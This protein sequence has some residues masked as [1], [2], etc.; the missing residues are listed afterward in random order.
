[1]CFFAITLNNLV[2]KARL[3]AGP[4]DGSTC[5]PFQRDDPDRGLVPG[6]GFD[7]TT[8]SH[9]NEAFGF[10]NI[11]VNWDYSPSRELTAMVYPTFEYLLII[12]LCFDFLATCLAQK[13]GDLAPWFWKFSQ[14][15]FGL[16]L[17]FC[18]QFRMIFVC[19]AYS[20]VRAHTAGFLGLQV[21]LI[22]VAMHNV[23]F[24][25][26]S[27]IAY[28]QLGGDDGGLANTRRAAVTYL[29]LDATI[30]I[31]KVSAT[32]Y[33]VATGHGAAWT[34][35]DTSIPNFKVGRIVDV[36]W[37]IFNAVIP[38]CLSYFRS[39]NDTP[40]N[41]VLTQAATYLQPSGEA[42]PLNA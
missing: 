41:I 17:F 39:K 8:N 6:K 33:A 37:M 23:M 10:N 36:I 26:E 40:I 11:C 19:L 2:V 13:R 24:V 14:V 3:L 16:N 1:M 29:V 22:L 7:V 32:I 25:W 42:T 20:S 28:K 27:N 35:V 12:Y 38:L 9:L 15:V 31:I 4:K 34:M 30:S 18:S 5:P 21:A